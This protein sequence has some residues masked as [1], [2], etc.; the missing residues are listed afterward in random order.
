MVMFLDN[1]AK[2]EAKI[3]I[4]KEGYLGMIGKGVF[5]PL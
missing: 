2:M 3:Y 5:G 1:Q 4:T